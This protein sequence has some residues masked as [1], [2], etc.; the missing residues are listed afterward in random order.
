MIEREFI[1]R[2]YSLVKPLGEGG[3]GTVFLAKDMLRNDEAVALKMVKW[4]TINKNVLNR[5]K[6]EF[7]IMTRLRHPHLAK[8]YDFGYDRQHGHY[9]LTMEYIEGTAL[10]D[11]L[12]LYQP[13]KDWKIEVFGILLRALSFIHSRRILHRDIKPQ[14][15]II[16]KDSLKLLDFGLSGLEDELRK[17]P[18]GT[19][20][21]MAPEVVEGRSNPQSD[22]FSLGLLFFEMLTGQSFYSV[23]EDRVNVVTLLRDLSYFNA[24]QQKVVQA[25]DDAGLQ[26]LILKMTNF[27]PELRYSDTIHVLNAVRGLYG[28]AIE[29]ETAETSEA[30][31]SGCVFIN[32]EKE[33]EKILHHLG[34]SQQFPLVLTGQEGIGKS[35]ILQELK[36]H[37]QVHDI[38]IFESEKGHFEASPYALFT[39][40]I[41]EMLIHADENLLRDYGST[42][43]RLLPFHEQLRDTV[44]HWVY[45][46]KL[47]HILIKNK[48]INFILEFIAQYHEVVVLC[49]DNIH[50]VREQALDVLN[51]L[52]SAMR[53][54][55]NLRIV[56]AVRNISLLNNFNFFRDR[57]YELLKLEPFDKAAVRSY[58]E[59]N[60]GEESIAESFRKAI[61][62][63][64]NA[65]GGNPLFLQ[66]VIRS[67]VEL[68]YI[69]RT[70]AGWVMTKDLASIDVPEHLRDVV[71][72][73]FNQRKLSKIEQR[74]I[75]LLAL[76]ERDVTFAELHEL[77]PFDS[78]ML[79]K[80]ERMELIRS[81]TSQGVSYYSITHEVLR[82]V[83]V[84]NIKDAGRLHRFI[85]EKLERSTVFDSEIYMTEI[86]YHFALG[87]VYQK[88]REYYLTA[89]NAARKRYQCQEAAL[90]YHRLES[91]IEEQG[92]PVDQEIEVNLGKVYKI[93][94]QWDKARAYFQKAHDI[95]RELE[96][97]KTLAE[98]FRGLGDVAQRLGN[99]EQAMD[100]YQSGLEYFETY[101][102]VYGF[103]ETLNGM[104]IVQQ[105]KGDIEAARRY[106]SRG[107]EIFYA[108]GHDP[109]LANPIGNLGNLY[110]M[111]GDYDS[112]MKYYRHFLTLCEK[113]DDIVG[114]SNT[115]GNIGLIYSARG[116]FDLAMS[117]YDKK[118][119]ISRDL[120]MKH[121]ISTTIGNVGNV[122]FETGN[123]DDAIECYN[124]WQQISEEIDH[125]IGILIANG[126]LGSCYL[127]K[128]EY[129][130]ALQY[131]NKAIECAYDINNEYY[132]CA[133]LVTKTALYIAQKKF[134]QAKSNNDRALFLCE[135]YK[136]E[137]LFKTRL[138]DAVIRAG[139]G[140][141]KEAA[142]LLNKYLI[143]ATTDSERLEIL[144]EQWHLDKTVEQADELIELSRKLYEETP[145]HLY[146]R[147]IDELKSWKQIYREKDLVSEEDI[148]LIKIT[149]PGEDLRREVEALQN[150][151]G[152]L[153]LKLEQL[154]R[155]I[156]IQPVATKLNFQEESRRQIQENEKEILEGLY[157]INAILNTEELYRTIISISKQLTKAERCFLVLV[158]EDGHWNFWSDESEE[159]G[160]FHHDDYNIGKN[161]VHR[162]IERNSPLLIRNCISDTDLV[163]RELI[164]YVDFL[165]VLC[166]PLTGFSSKQILGVLYLDIKNPNFEFN[167]YHLQVMKV[168][169]NQ[170]AISMENARLFGESEKSRKTFDLVNKEL[171]ELTLMKSK[172]TS[173]VIHQIDTPFHL[174]RNYLD[175]FKQSSETK[176]D[177]MK[178]I[179]SISSEAVTRFSRN[180]KNIIELVR[181]NRPETRAKRKK[182]SMNRLLHELERVVGPLV[183][184]RNQ[185]L[186]M[187]LPSEEVF[188]Y[189]DYELI[190]QALMQLLLN[191]IRFTPDYGMIHVKL[192]HS[193]QGE[194]IH[195]RDTGIGIE[196]DEFDNIFREFYT[197]QELDY[198]SSGTIEFQSGGLGMGLSLAKAIIDRH[199]G[200][201]LVQSTVGQG[202]TFSVYIPV[203]K[204]VSDSKHQ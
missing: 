51:E 204:I 42:L 16:T 119:Q 131:C 108:N 194:V 44:P 150:R 153:K 158:E 23:I 128:G 11:Y 8:V 121:S 102:D 75:E 73:R 104:G 22:I 19:V 202:T 198:H 86:A 112:A 66:E 105:R 18:A 46:Q 68:K 14:N 197:I 155:S 35:R 143:E 162:V 32:R 99:Y 111:D 65:V 6:Y 174:I 179:L 124:K 203:L 90:L 55:Q 58:I 63:I 188:S 28:E 20:L 43:K 199:N 166:I 15:I 26:Q 85:A 136:N 98:A 178:N 80:L 171:E 192:D 74:L 147:H 129:D 36:H 200:R 57:Q 172:F 180:M 138:M 110:Y 189:F 29:I 30:Y 168:I 156:D 191:G 67:F 157:R 41:S 151:L 39:P 113:R 59:M 95:S 69:V 126:N 10:D 135:K 12:N 7:T 176:S 84:S 122:H 109:K 160:V 47:E 154:R 24:Y 76:F 93:L 100:Y 169:A 88:A 91:L 87:G 195:V 48:L 175:I 144:Y 116:N 56:C 72:M 60:F 62:Y 193:E 190:W 140:N 1:N 78:E 34:S 170:A 181:L 79:H 97:Y 159:Q 4:E 117:C 141:K 45:D 148:A 146:Q 81:K 53:R 92:E 120:G 21:Y 25:I 118:L 130:K 165:S 137:L 134:S 52:F 123:F 89:A 64:W 115:I 27:A 61:P 103:A 49:F 83:I 161:I 186:E 50:E 125:K 145:R 133:P 183:K 96:D 82:R 71:S 106:F 94:C 139:L 184:Q 152:S 77:V 163:K 38:P 185:T 17:K 149:G 31:I 40:I 101:K 127:L 177:Y 167:E 114:Y 132:L 142:G 201:I 196:R 173:L 5:F 182:Q 9:Y 3:M 187:Q 2:R 164:L 107:E 70:P 33:W 13:G 54:N 37:C